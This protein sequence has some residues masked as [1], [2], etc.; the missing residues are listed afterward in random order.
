MYIRKDVK[1]LVLSLTLTALYLFVNNMTYS[2]C[3]LRGVC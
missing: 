3:V 1:Y 2:D